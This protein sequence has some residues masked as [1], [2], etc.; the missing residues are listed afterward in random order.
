[1]SRDIQAVAIGY[2]VMAGLVFVLFSGAYLVMGP[3]GAFQPG[4]F[5]PS[6][7][8]IVV[9][10]ILGLIGAIVGGLVCT[11]IAVRSKAH[12]ALA[13]VVFVLGLLMAVPVLTASDPT[14]KKERTAEVGTMEA[15]TNGRQPSWVALLNPVVGAAGVV[16]GARI[17]KKT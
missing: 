11:S 9:S 17:R 3:G 7:T 5:D 13:G 1:M 12:I 4:S 6:I 8:W 2:L 15:M 14:V 10:F 16:I